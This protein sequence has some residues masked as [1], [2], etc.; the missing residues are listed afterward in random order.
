M[1]NTAKKIYKSKSHC[2]FIYVGH[3]QSITQ[4]TEWLQ[5][6]FPTKQQRTRPDS[7]NQLISVFRQLISKSVCSWVVGTKTCSHLA[8]CGIVWTCLVYAFT[9]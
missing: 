2:T 1:L 6:F 7:F 5:I 3:V 9:K 4:R 8:L